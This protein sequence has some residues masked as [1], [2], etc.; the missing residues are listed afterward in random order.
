TLYLGRASGKDNRPIGPI[1]YLNSYLSLI[2]DS[3]GVQGVRIVAESVCQALEL[4]S[5]VPKSPGFGPGS[6]AGPDVEGE[7][8]AS[9]VIQSRVDD[10]SRPPDSRILVP[11]Q[12]PYA[13][14][15]LHPG[16]CCIHGGCHASQTRFLAVQNLLHSTSMLDQSPP[17][18]RPTLRPFW[19]RIPE[20]GPS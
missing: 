3:D 16:Q 6:L 7:D 12:L 14:N 19:P 1:R 11:E 4:C 8:I 18:L 9:D 13:G 17:W 2:L 20:P 15:A 10:R 5:S